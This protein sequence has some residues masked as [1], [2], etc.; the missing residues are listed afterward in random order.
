MITGV[1]R[2][3]TIIIAPRPRFRQRRAHSAATGLSPPVHFSPRSASQRS[4]SSAAERAKVRHHSP[5]VAES[6]EFRIAGGVSPAHELPGGVDPAGFGERPAQRADIR[7]G[8]AAVQESS[9][10]PAAVIG[11]AGYWPA[12]LM[13]LAW[14]KAPP[15]VPR[16]CI[17]PPL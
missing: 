6:V 4:A 1:I 3:W 15:S 8:A 16:S 13:A 7:H 12:S 10:H 2:F 5:G 14:L 17:V 11:K 9:S